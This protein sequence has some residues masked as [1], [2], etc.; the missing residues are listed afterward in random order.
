MIFIINNKT[1]EIFDFGKTDRSHISCYGFN[2]YFSEIE[3]KELD[4]LI[5]AAL[6]ESEKVFYKNLTSLREVLVKY[7]NLKLF[8]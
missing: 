4:S 1:Y 7:N 2:F 8:K 6:P 3:A 5:A